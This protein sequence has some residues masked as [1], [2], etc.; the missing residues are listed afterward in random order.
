MAAVYEKQSFGLFEVG[1]GDDESVYP[2]RNRF[3]ELGLS[4]AFPPILIKET[5]TE[6]TY[7]LCDEAG[8]D[9][10]QWLT[11]DRSIKQMKS[12]N[13]DVDKALGRIS[14]GLYIITA[15]KGEASSAMLAS[16]VAQASLEPL[17]I[18]IAVAKDRAI[19]SFMHAGDRFV[20]NVL[21]EGNY[22]SLMKHFLKRFA[23]GADRFEGVK[24][25]LP[26]MVLPFWPMLWHT[27]SV[28]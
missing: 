11:R 21:Q 17:G 26:T 28:R 2:L 8:T 5:P 3:Q 22:Q 14:G 19:E 15:K 20:L 7:Q 13:G 27:W 6:T 18:T 23:P 24:P 16:W 1:G 9:L 4:E 25:T 10:G 12:L